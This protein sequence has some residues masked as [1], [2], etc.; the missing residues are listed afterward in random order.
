L[1]PAAMGSVRQWQYGRTL[2]YGQPIPTEAD[3]DIVF[4]LP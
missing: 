3:I 4:R 2:H 1:I